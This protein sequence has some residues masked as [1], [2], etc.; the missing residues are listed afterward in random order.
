[1][2]GLLPTANEVL[3][4]ALHCYYSGQRGVPSS[5]LM[6]VGCENEQGKV[7]KFFGLSIWTNFDP[8]DLWAVSFY[9]NGDSCWTMA[10]CCLTD[11]LD[12]RIVIKPQRS[13]VS[14]FLSVRCST[15]STFQFTTRQTITMLLSMFVL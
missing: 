11:S 12:L 10:L 7:L 2:V 3:F 4:A 9:F 8:F 13:S 14:A 15:A 1:M 5:E 6:T